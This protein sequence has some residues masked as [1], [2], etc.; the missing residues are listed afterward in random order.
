MRGANRQDIAGLRFGR[1]VAVCVAGRTKDRKLQWLCK[2]D[3]GNESVVIGTDLRSHA[4]ESCGCLSLERTVAQGR[5]NR[6]HGMRYTTTYET[7]HA[8]LAR[9][10]N[11]LNAR[12]ADYGGRGIAVCERWHKFENLAIRI[13]VLNGASCD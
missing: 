13:A 11:P 10:E 1:L 3:C 6:V 5:R 12:Y 7:W 2:C 8:M 4:T 9:C